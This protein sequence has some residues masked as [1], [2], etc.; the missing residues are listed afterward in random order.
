[1]RLSLL[2]PLLAFAAVASAQ[3]FF[4]GVEYLEEPLAGL[5]TKTLYLPAAVRA[6]PPVCD[7]VLDDPVW[8]EAQRLTGFINPMT[9]QRPVDPM[10]GWIARGPDGLYVAVRSVAKIPPRAENAQSLS[11]HSELLRCL[12]QPKLAHWG[13]YEVGVSGGSD[14]WYKGEAN[15][16][17]NHRKDHIV[18]DWKPAVPATGACKRHGDAIVSEFI[19]PFATVSDRPPAPGEEWGFDIERYYTQ[20]YP[21]PNSDQTQ[22]EHTIGAWGGACAGFGIGPIPDKWGRICFGA[23]AFRAAAFRA[24]IVRVYLD[25]SRYGNADEAGEGYV[26]VLFGSEPASAFALKLHLLDAGG[27]V[28]ESRA[29]AK[30]RT[31]AAGVQFDPRK[32]KNGDY[33]LRATLQRDGRDVA[34]GERAFARYPGEPLPKNAFDAIGIELFNDPRLGLD[35]VALPVSIGVP[36]P[37]G[38]FADTSKL[39]LQ[40]NAEGNTIYPAGRN[41]VNVPAQFDVRD[42]WYRGGS[43]RWLGVSF[44]A[45]YRAGWPAR[46]RLVWNAKE[47]APAFEKALKIEESDA[48]ITVTT[49]PARFVLSKGGFNL[50]SAAWLDADGDGQFTEAEQ[51]I[52]AGA[53]DGLWYENQTRARLNAAHTGTTLTI[54]ESG[55]QRTVIA[56]EGW[57]Q[58][59][60]TREC[61]QKTRLFFSRNSATVKIKHSWINTADSRAQRVR[62]ISLKLGVPGVRTCAFGGEE[63][64]YSAADVPPG[65]LYQIQLTSKSCP[66]ETEVGRAAGPDFGRMGGWLYAGTARGGVSLAGRDLWKL[67]PKE[68]AVGPAGV[69]LYLWPVHG[70]EVYPEDHQ[71]RIPHLIQLLSAHQGRE[72]SFQMPKSYYE[73]LGAYWDAGW[74]TNARPTAFGPFI[75]WKAWRGYNANAQGVALSAEVDITLHAP[76]AGPQAAARAAMLLDADPHG[77]ADP[78]WTRFTNAIGPVHEKD[79]LR[80]GAVEKLI[81]DTFERCFIRQPEELDDYGMLNWP[82]YHNYAFDAWNP[83]PG[84]FHRCWS[85][86]HYQDARAFYHQYL[87]SGE[88][89][90]WRLANAKFRHSMDIDAVNYG[91]DPPIAP[92]HQRGATY[93]PKGLL[94]WGGNGFV[95]CHFACYDYMLYDYFLTGDPRGRDFVRMWA[96]EIN[97]DGWVGNPEREATAPLAEALFVY[98]HLRDPRMLKMIDHHRNGMLVCELQDHLALPYFNYMLWWRANE[99]TA[100]PRVRERL[101]AHWGDGSAAKKHG[102]GHGLEQYMIYKFTGDRRL[103]AAAP[104][105][106][107]KL[108]WP[109]YTIPVSMAYMWGAVPFIMTGMEEAGAS[110]DVMFGGAAWKAYWNPELDQWRK[111][112]KKIWGK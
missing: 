10:E 74:R 61:I 27:K 57:Y 7:G 19:I 66:I 34:A 68:L 105:L 38:M 29:D 12:L 17:V 85:N 93:H 28:V 80:F 73:K 98:Q 96:G 44:E 42:R 97:R 67:Y 76:G 87:R 26:E 55:P 35:E 18:P 36:L 48:A 110:G 95:I 81:D 104:L 106:D 82:D 40:V 8:K 109:R 107:A 15:T 79:P 9:G 84:S 72:L 102:L 24:P 31:G 59:G 33:I 5:R 112:G 16:V 94:H 92:F 56:A 37:K 51:L 32:L 62:E 39:V 54:V 86:N 89:K 99:Y 20:H 78:K 46:H 111:D 4:Q 3:G 25:R 22:V 103:M 75:F 65:G 41:W 64:G 50:I 14:A 23:E 49:G 71:L 11:R 90:Y 52:R 13:G 77:V 2:L 70:R 53:E 30:P 21:I 108:L 91:D 58:A 101:V 1:M 47:A 83:N 43:L 45:R 69:A 88:A 63:G 100:D 6:A 60:A